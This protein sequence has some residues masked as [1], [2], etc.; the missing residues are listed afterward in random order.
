M[1]GT[2]YRKYLL[3]SMSGIKIIVVNGLNHLVRLPIL[4][5]VEDSNMCLETYGPN[6]APLT[7][8]DIL[9]AIDMTANLVNKLNTH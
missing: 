4:Y 6:S 7:Q 1:N 8:Q 3:I 9:L 5:Y 2:W